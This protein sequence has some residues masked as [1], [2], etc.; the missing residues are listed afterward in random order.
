MLGSQP[1]YDWQL[2]FPRYLHISRLDLRPFDRPNLKTYLKM[3]GLGP[4][5]ISVDGLDGVKLL[6]S[7]YS[8]IQLII[9]LSPYLCFHFL[10][11]SRCVCTIC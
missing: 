3:R 2:C 1:N 6:N 9:L 8:S 11:I 4:D 7:F 10:F 5:A